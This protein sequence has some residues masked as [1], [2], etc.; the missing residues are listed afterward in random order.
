M[1]NV[2]MDYAPRRQLA[3]DGC[4]VMV[5]GD[6]LLSRTSHPF[7]Y[8]GSPTSVSSTVLTVPTLRYLLYLSVKLGQRWPKWTFPCFGED[9]LTTSR[10]K[11][12]ALRL[13]EWEVYWV[14]LHFTNWLTFGL[15]TTLPSRRTAK[16][17][18]LS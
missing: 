8:F 15:V 17:F 12:R 9:D 10:A 1:V 6:G 3:D 7:Q 2:C 18:E 5:A 4:V 14:L 13:G 11:W 16:R